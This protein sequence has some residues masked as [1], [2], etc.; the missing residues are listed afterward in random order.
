[1][2]RVQLNVQEN[3]TIQMLLKYKK[4]P[5]KTPIPLNDIQ[6]MIEKLNIPDSLDINLVLG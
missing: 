4:I 5:V 2:L 3:E 1:M 6:E